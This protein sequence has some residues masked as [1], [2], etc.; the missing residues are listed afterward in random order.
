[1]NQ[2]DSITRYIEEENIDVAFVSE[3]CERE[4]KRL[5]DHTNLNQRQDNEN[6]KL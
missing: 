2:I 5:E 6:M 3:T 4:N 1:M